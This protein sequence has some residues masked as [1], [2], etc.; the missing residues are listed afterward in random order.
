MLDLQSFHWGSI[1]VVAIANM[2]LG[3]LWYSPVLFGQLWM[4]LSHHHSPP[5]KG[6]MKAYIGGFI[7]A[8]VTAFVLSY[9]FSKFGIYTMAEASCFAFMVW[10]GFLATAGF[11]G[12]LW[13]KKPVKLYLIHVGF[14]LVSLQ[15][16]SWILVSLN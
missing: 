12:V 6:M 13:E 2:L 8:F 4:K 14:S 15:V 1:L 16:M 9:F 10:L 11:G 7:T 5:K 3:S